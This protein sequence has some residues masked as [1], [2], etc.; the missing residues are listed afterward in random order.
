[1]AKDLVGF[2][3]SIW[4]GAFSSDMHLQRVARAL[5]TPKTRGSIHLTTYWPYY[6]LAS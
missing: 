2:I 5:Y 4:L 3:G 6:S 1:M